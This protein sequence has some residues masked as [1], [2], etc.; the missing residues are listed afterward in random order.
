MCLMKKRSKT[1]ALI[2]VIFIELVKDLVLPTKFLTTL[3]TTE[4]EQVNAMSQLM[5]PGITGA[6][7]DQKVGVSLVHLVNL[8]LWT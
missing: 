3:M 7:R 1:A 8:F 2:L 4:M 5:N 6:S